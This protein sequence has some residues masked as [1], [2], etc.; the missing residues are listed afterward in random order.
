MLKYSL[1]L[2]PLDVRFLLPFV[3]D[4]RFLFIFYVFLNQISLYR[5]DRLDRCYDLVIFLIG[6]VSASRKKKIAAHW[7]AE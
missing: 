6:F 4:C 7:N 1:G 5:T 3:Y 2:D